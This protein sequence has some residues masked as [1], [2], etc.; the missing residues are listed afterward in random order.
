MS[1]QAAAGEWVEDPILRIRMRM[2]REEEALL[3]DVYVQ[4]GGGI[5]R[6]FHPHQDELWEVLE[7]SARFH[8][9][10]TKRVLKAGEQVMVHTGERHALKNV[11]DSIARLRFTARPA[12]ELEEFLLDA[13]ALNSSG[14]VTSFGLPKSFGAL[15]DGAAF[16]ERYRETCVL[17]FPLPP[18]AVQRLLMGPLARLARRRDR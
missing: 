1:E 11:G 5:G 10:R 17:L 2:W 7:G 9:G 12:M 3:G 4:P 18:P 16:V 6:H 13:V 14:E 15:L 8:I